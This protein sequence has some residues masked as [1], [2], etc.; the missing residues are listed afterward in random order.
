[1]RQFRPVAGATIGAVF[2]R[3]N[4]LSV[5]VKQELP[6]QNRRLGELLATISKEALPKGASPQ[7]M[8]EQLLS[9]Y[10]SKFEVLGLSPGEE[11]GFEDCVGDIIGRA[12]IRHKV[13]AQVARSSWGLEPGVLRSTHGALITPPSLP[14]KN[15][16]L[17][18]RLAVVAATVL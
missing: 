14:K 5:T 16:G 6:A 9:G 10:Q 13:M 11:F 4:Q 7:H 15:S 2:R 18:R 8:G 17:L 3:N 1:M 12:M